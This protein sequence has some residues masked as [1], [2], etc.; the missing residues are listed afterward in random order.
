VSLRRLPSFPPPRAPTSR[1]AAALFAVASLGSSSCADLTPRDG[2]IIK[3]CVD[4]DSDPAHDVDFGD[5]IRPIMNG[6]VPGTQGC[7]QCH[8]DTESSHIGIDQ[9]GLNLTELEYIRQGGNN[10]HG[11]VV[12]PGKPCDSAIVQKLEG[13]FHIGARMPK[14]GP[15]WNDAQIQLMID[16]IAEGAKGE[17]DD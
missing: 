11:T 13:S 5:D 15:F 12:I 2:V 3:S 9:S 10:T 1:I 8:Y 4:G 6:A 7:K 14:N 17:D 16:W